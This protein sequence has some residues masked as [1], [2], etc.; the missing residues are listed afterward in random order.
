MT[1]E[2]AAKAIGAKG[3]KRFRTEEDVEFAL[4]AGQVELQKPIEYRWYGELL[5]HDP[6]PRHL[7]RRGRPRR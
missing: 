6:G 7:Q 4:E 1:A 3:L 2:Q 5:A